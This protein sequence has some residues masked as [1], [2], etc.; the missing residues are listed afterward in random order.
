MI[1]DFIFSKVVLAV[2]IRSKQN[3][4]QRCLN[5]VGGSYS[6]DIGH[7]KDVKEKEQLSH[8]VDWKAVKCPSR[9]LDIWPHLSPYIC[10][11]L[12]HLFLDWLSLLHRHMAKCGYPYTDQPAHQFTVP[13]F[14]LK[15]VSWS[16]FSTP[17][18]DDQTGR[19]C[20]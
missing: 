20:L 19:V 5:L 16:P 7:I 14:R 3:L 13:L 1:S 2:G 9:T 11:T 8:R 6:K 10:M 4:K 17:V 12:L 15:L 18:G